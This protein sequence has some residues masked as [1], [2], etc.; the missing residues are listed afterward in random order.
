MRS[1]INNERI[2]TILLV[3]SLLEI[4]AQ[5]GHAESTPPANDNR[6]SSDKIDDFWSRTLKRT[7]SKSLNAQ[8]ELVNEPVQYVK[9][10]VTYE[11][12]DGV[13]IRAYLA[14]PYDTGS[15]V[16]RRFPAI[17]TGPG[18]RGDGWGLE[19]SESLRGYVI[20]HVCPRSQGESAELWK[21]DGPDFLTWHIS[22]PEGYFYQG[23]YM[24][25]V[26]GVDYL[27][28]RP[29]VDPNRI[30]AIGISQGGGLALAVAALDPRIKAVVARIPFLCDMRLAAVAHESLAKT[31]LNRYHALTPQNLSTLD[32]FDQLNLAHRNHAATL[33]CAGGKDTT[34]PPQTIQAVFDQLPGIK[35]LAVYPNMDH[36]SGSD[37][38]S[39]ENF[40]DMTWDWAQ[41]YLKG[42]P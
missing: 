31:L 34:C 15:K 37:S 17:I 39:T 33:L 14:K 8:E 35:A 22:R 28:S 38:V 2:R 12:L 18:Y 13:K 27:C 29:D 26:R 36:P 6:P 16:P 24:D 3:L 9:I 42:D 1:F 23:A 40:Y 20:L 25:M 10:R 41:R 30:G 11:S 4:V 19:L 7:E 21:I 32:Y 5:I